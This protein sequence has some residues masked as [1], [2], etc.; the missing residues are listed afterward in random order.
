MLVRVQE[1][2]GIYENLARNDSPAYV[3]CTRYLQHGY[4]CSPVYQVGRSTCQNPKPCSLTYVRK[5]KSGEDD[6][7]L[8]VPTASVAGCQHC[9]PAERRNILS[10]RSK[11]KKR[12]DAINR[13]VRTYQY[14]GMN[15]NIKHSWILLLILKRP[16][17]SRMYLLNSLGRDS[18]G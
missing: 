16:L 17:Y 15:L 14:Q 8:P 3:S 13:L 10:R 4:C 18:R 2:P 5:T 6:R 9:L 7:E 1:I 11:L 12:C